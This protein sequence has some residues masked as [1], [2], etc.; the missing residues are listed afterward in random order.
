MD[1][2]PMKEMN[3]DLPYK[4][5]TPYAHMCGH[6]GH[7][8]MLLSACQLLSKRLS[9]IPSNKRI[10]ILFQPA[11][12]GPGGAK[13]MIEEGCLEGVDEVYGLHNIPNFPAG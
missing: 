2:L 12:E 13:P 1:A 7:M 3:T 10:R 11:E 6:D 4:T 8:V 5:V 9:K